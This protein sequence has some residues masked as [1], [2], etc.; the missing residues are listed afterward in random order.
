MISE[1]KKQL[2][3]LFAEGRR[4][5]KLMNFEEALK[6]FQKAR[7]IEPD[8]GPARVYEVRCKHYIKNPPEEDWDGV[9]TM[10]TK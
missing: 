1:E 6:F 8:D 10:K 2:L 4:Q 7:T 5:Y 9:F 3:D